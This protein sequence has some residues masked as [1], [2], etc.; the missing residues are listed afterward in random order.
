MS[1]AIW[2]CDKNG[3]PLADVY[4]ETRWDVAELC[5]AL[6]AEGIGYSIE[7][8]YEEPRADADVGFTVHSVGDGWPDWVV[9]TEKRGLMYFDGSGTEFHGASPEF[10]AIEVEMTEGVR[11]EWLEKRRNDAD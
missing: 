1:G 7:H 10:V 11:R 6:K 5:G 2:T 8:W 9:M 4:V 3:R